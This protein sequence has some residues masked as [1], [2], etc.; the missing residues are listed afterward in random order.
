MGRRY[1][2]APREFVRHPLAI[3]LAAACAGAFGVE[4]LA[5]IIDDRLSLLT[6]GRRTAPARRQT[7]RE[8]FDWSYDLLSEPERAVMRRLAAFVGDFSMESAIL[9]AGDGEMDPANIRDNE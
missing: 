7:L 1:E 6:D 9:A 5:S 4:G 2:T 8:T 3:E